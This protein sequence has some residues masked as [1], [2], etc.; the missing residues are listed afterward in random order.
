MLTQEDVNVSINVN[1]FFKEITY[2][3]KKNAS[4]GI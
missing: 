4:M 1:I 3:Q 2:F